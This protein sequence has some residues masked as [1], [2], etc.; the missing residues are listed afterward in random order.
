MNVI[1]GENPV[2]I[3]SCAARADKLKTGKICFIEPTFLWAS[4]KP[5]KSPT[6]QKVLWEDELDI[7]SDQVSKIKVV[8]KASTKFDR[9]VVLFNY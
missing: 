2:D 1:F 3:A 5:F 4:K 7:N 9:S 6:S 8:C